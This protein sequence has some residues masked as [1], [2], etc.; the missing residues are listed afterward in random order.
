MVALLNIIQEARNDKFE[1]KISGH[2]TVLAA[3]AAKLADCA[4]LYNERSRCC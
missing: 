2:I 4:A 3:F 1:F